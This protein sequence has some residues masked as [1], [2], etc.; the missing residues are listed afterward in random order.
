[1]IGGPTP[2]GK[3]HTKNDVQTK[4]YP[5]GGPTCFILPSLRNLNLQLFYLIAAIASISSGGA[6]RA[7][8]LRARQARQTRR[9]AVKSANRKFSVKT[10][11]LK[12]H[13]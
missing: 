5:M 6:D 3:S 1:M 10:L 13:R 2:F 8:P 7:A 4:A 11:L 9:K 12:I